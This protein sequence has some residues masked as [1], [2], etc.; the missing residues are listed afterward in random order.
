[1]IPKIA[2]TYEYAHLAG[3]ETIRSTAMCR[4]SE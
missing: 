3:V 2:S 1:L 4:K